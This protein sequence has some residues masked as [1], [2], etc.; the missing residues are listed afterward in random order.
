MPDGHSDNRL[1]IM[2]QF[3]LAFKAPKWDV[4]TRYSE[5]TNHL[6]TS[7]LVDRNK[8]SKG[9]CW[10]VRYR[11]KPF[12]YWI[13]NETYHNCMDHKTTHCYSKLLGTNLKRRLSPE[14][15]HAPTHKLTNLANGKPNM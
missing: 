11:E 10:S 4:T 6:L 7:G 2:Q 14:V 12:N 15:L 9:T 8:P 13:K 3:Q 5:K 1:K